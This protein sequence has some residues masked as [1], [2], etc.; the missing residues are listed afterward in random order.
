MAKAV[1]FIFVFTSSFPDR[2]WEDATLFCKQ[3]HPVNEHVSETTCPAPGVEPCGPGRWP[4]T[5]RQPEG[6]LVEFHPWRRGHRQVLDMLRCFRCFR[7]RMVTRRPPWRCHPE[8]GQLRLGCFWCL[9]RPYKLM[10][11]CFI[12]SLLALAPSLWPP[13]VA[14]SLSAH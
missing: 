14:C 8:L 11:Q 5:L 3:N 2:L 12:C 4:P 9:G 1:R 10:S 13:W 6:C 7:K